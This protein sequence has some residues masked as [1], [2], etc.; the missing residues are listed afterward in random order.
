MLRARVICAAE[1]AM[2]RDP[3]ARSLT[4]VAAGLIAACTARDSAPATDTGQINAAAACDTAGARAAVERFGER[5]RDVSL[6]APDTSVKRQIRETYSPYVTAGLLEV[7]VA[8]PDS[9]PGRKVSSPWPERIA[10][11]TIDAAGLYTCRVE[12]T[13]VYVTSA[14]QT[15][16]GDAIR[17][18]VVLRLTRDSV[19][20]IDDYDVTEPARGG[21]TAPNESAGIE[22]LS[23]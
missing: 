7:W 3:F 4:I 15:A 1:P 23:G 11:E 14:D 22:R 5:L 10:I 9:A 6:L 19:W 21:R 17:E 2:T 8:H 16:G 20:R 12:G 13:V 18:R